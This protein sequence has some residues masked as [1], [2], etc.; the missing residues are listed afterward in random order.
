MNNP[1][2]DCSTSALIKL[3][4]IDHVA[5]GVH[6]SDLERVTLWYEKTFSLNRL[7]ENIITARNNGMKMNVLKPAQGNFSIV[8]AASISD[9]NQTDHLKSFV[10]QNGPG[11]QHIAFHCDILNETATLKNTFVQIVE[12]PPLYYKQHHVKKSLEVVNLSVADVQKGNILIDCD[13]IIQNKVLMQ[14]FTKPIL[15]NGVF[16]EL[17]QRWNESDGFGDNNVKALWEG[18]EKENSKHVGDKKISLFNVRH[19]LFVVILLLL[20]YF[21]MPGAL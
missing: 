17:I 7:S 12:P 20:C 14:A 13:D 15:N 3:Q 21:A 10:E 2:H 18:I 4:Y 5:I 1:N 8:I 11:V 9:S 16:F 6:I 19:I